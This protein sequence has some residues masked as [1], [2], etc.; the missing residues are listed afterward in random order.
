MRFHTIIA[1]GKPMPEIYAWGIQLIHQIQNVRGPLLDLFFKGITFLGNESFYLLFFPIFYWCVDFKWGYRL[2][3]IFLVSGY[4]NT[5]LKEL[6]AQPRPFELEAG[7]NLVEAHGFGLPSGHAQMAVVIWGYLAT[8]IKK[9]WFWLL[10][11]LLMVLIGFSRI[12]LGVHFPTDVL[13]GWLLGIVLLA[14]ALFLKKPTTSLEISFTLLVIGV[15]TLTALALLLQP[16]KDTISIIAAFWGFALGLLIFRR[17]FPLHFA[18]SLFQRILRLSVGLVG[19]ILLY[20]GLKALLPGEGYRLYL[21][22]RF[23]RYGSLGFWIS[24]GAPFLFRLLGLVRE[25]TR[26]GPSRE[27]NSE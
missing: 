11:G 4:A 16:T 19:L 15:N 24:L 7:L 13:G 9:R 17:F 10:A 6:L 25:E 20:L 18:G 23:L 14:A 22:F 2:G 27:E 3:I 21:P 26:N 5:A 12:Y 8:L 1:W